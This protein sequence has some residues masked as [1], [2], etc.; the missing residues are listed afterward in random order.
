[1]CDLPILD[2]TGEFTNCWDNFLNS[3]KEHK[4][5]DQS[6]R[7]LVKNV[8]TKYNGQ[9]IEHIPPGNFGLEDCYVRFE[10][11]K[12]LVLFLLKFS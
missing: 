3:V 5:A 9:L 1:M 10:D 6:W 8:L 2:N 12:S 11:E 7:Q 4:R